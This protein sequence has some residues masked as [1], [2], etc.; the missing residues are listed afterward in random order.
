MN[1]GHTTGPLKTARR[2]DGGSAEAAAVT[3]GW[4]RGRPRMEDGSAAGISRISE[5][6]KN[7]EAK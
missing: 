6:G 7:N 4:T 5:A 1:K 2:W 3:A